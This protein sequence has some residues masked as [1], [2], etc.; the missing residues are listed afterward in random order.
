MRRRTILVLLGGAF[1]A[2]LAGP[3]LR[4]AAARPPAHLYRLGVL[5]PIF[6]HGRHEMLDLILQV[7][8]EDG[9]VEGRNLSVE[10][11]SAVGRLDILPAL[12]S[13]LVR[14]ELDVIVA[15]APPAIRAIQ[16]AT[17]TI[18]VVMISGDD[19]VRSGFVP[20]L[21]RP[22]G[23]ITG[24]ALLADDLA[25]KRLELLTLA[26]PSARRV[27]VLLNPGNPTSRDRLREVGVAAAAR[28]IQI[29]VVEAGDTAHLDESL[30]AVAR[31]RPDAL[32]VFADPI[33]FRHRDRIGEFAGK[34][35]LPMV[36]DWRQM[37]EAGAL[38]AYGPSLSAVARRVAIY[39]ER[40][41]Q[42]AH[43]GDLP[44]EQPT[45]VD[46]VVNV[47]TARALRVE[48]P[49]SLLLR[50]DHVIE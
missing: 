29:V 9:L 34:S 43:P 3:A 38:I 5:S 11:R 16:H 31:A 12:A 1:V 46:L 39:I 17:R 42:G 24:V 22:G 8:A 15:E 26:L 21:A 27:A 10:V 7:L 19:P 6:V 13:E 25:V 4:S 23:N 2:P 47:R 40:I 49:R 18:P 37:A 28:G 20:S 45:E 14:L 50:A 30:A 33:F 48:L 41:L 32:L 35:R 44:V 36:S